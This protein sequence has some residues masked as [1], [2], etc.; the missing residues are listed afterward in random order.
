MAF[1][2]EVVVSWVVL[3]DSMMGKSDKAMLG[4]RFLVEGFFVR[5]LVRAM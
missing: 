3:V 2:G 5:R 1:T 4:E